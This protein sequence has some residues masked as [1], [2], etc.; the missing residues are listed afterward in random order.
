MV[1]SAAENIQDLHSILFQYDFMALSPTTTYQTLDTF[2]DH[3]DGEALAVSKNSFV[4]LVASYVNRTQSLVSDLSGRGSLN[5]LTRCT[6][7]PQHVTAANYI[8]ANFKNSNLTSSLQAFQ[9]PPAVKTQNVIGVKLGVSTPEEVIVIGGHYDSTSDQCAI[10][11]PGAVDNAGGCSM[12]MAIAR[13]A[14]SITFDRTIH[15][16]CFG[17]EEQGLYGSQYYVNTNGTSVQ[18][19]IIADM[20]GYSKNYYGVTLEGRLFNYHY[21]FLLSSLV[22]QICCD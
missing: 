17:G 16:I 4:S 14:M 13:A 2:L 22:L 8:L 10:L 21:F 11:A 6:Y 18:G 3:K 9:I 19:A 15:F 7:S 20:I 1:A 5:I 12:V